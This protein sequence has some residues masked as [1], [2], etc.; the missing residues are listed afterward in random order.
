M[1]EDKRQRELQLHL[2]QLAAGHSL[3]WFLLVLCLKNLYCCQ[4]LDPI[5][6]KLPF[7]ALAGQGILLTGKTF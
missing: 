4:S 7:S 2:E 1:R 5:I 3:I 6:L